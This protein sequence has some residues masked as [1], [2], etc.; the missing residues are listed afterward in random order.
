MEVYRQ[1]E[2]R[3]WKNNPGTMQRVFE[4]QNTT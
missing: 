4:N 2:N 3:R 1:L